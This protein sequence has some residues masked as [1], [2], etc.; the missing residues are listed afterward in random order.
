MS[1]SM[2]APLAALCI[3]CQHYPSAEGVLSTGSERRCDSWSVE[4]SGS[5]AASRLAP[6]MQITT[7]RI[8]DSQRGHLSPI[9]AFT[10][11]DLPLLAGSAGTQCIGPAAVPTG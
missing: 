4:Q 6:V 7:V 2:S 9:T 8:G 10:A 5:P 11:G 1:G 3:G